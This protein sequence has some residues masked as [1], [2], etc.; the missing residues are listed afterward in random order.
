[1]RWH[2]RLRV[3]GWSNALFSHE[4]ASATSEG[5][6]ITPA[7]ALQVDA[8]THTIQLT[9]PASALGRRG[10]LKGARVWINTWDWDARYRALLPQPQDYSFGGGRPDEPRIM[11]ATEV[12]VLP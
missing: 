6:A 3:G 5:R 9:L 11:D 1:M 10:T 2:R 12:L 7:A 4:G 8:A